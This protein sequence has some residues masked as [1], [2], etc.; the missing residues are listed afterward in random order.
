MDS[1]ADGLES[2]CRYFPPRQF[3]ATVINSRRNMKNTVILACSFLALVGCTTAAPRKG[4]LDFSL[5]G[6]KKAA[7]FVFLAPDCPFS[8][9]Y[10]LTL[11]DLQA[12]FAADSVAFY[13]VVAG[14]GFRKAEI[15]EFAQAYKIAFPVLPDRNFALADFFHAMKT[16]E[17]F[18]VNSRA[19]LIYKG[20]IDNWAADFGRHR[21]TI[22]EHY[23]LD[24][25]NSWIR[26]D[27][28]PIKE[29]EAVGCF[30][31]RKG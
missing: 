7:V 9:N 27:E 21:R 30:I 14:T 5:L 19:D 29:T 17:A 6:D 20:A 10:T 2:K 25:L 8:Q 23:L 1:I 22:T 15:D 11:N 28:V 18:V 24:A 4:S 26:G 3:G 13:G 12:Q 16:P 31:E